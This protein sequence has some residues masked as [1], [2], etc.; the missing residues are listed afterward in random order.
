[1][2]LIFS[3]YMMFGEIRLQLPHSHFE[4]TRVGKI[5]TQSQ[6]IDHSELER[7][8]VQSHADVEAS[9]AHGLLCGMLCVEN[10]IDVELWLGQVLGDYDRND[11]LVMEVRETLVSVYA[12]TLAQLLGG[13]FELDILLPDDESDLGDRID[14]LS[15]WCQGFLF[16]M[17]AA[18]VSNV[19]N[20]PGDVGEVVQD[21]LDISKAGYD[22]EQDEEQNEKAY[23]EVVEY[24]RVGAMLVFNEFNQADESDAPPTIH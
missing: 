9:E 24:L 3:D 16:G 19:E 5:L 13:E 22:S 10:H 4:E 17:S 11:L 6:Q 1:M 2:F 14:E 8:L 15:R 18:G 12:N 21:F 23:A 7:V 20:L